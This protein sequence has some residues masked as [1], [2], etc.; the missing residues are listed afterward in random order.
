M[1]S[2]R[3]GL[4]A[5]PTF[6]LLFHVNYVLMGKTNG[7]QRKRDA[8][9]IGTSVKRCRKTWIYTL[10]L[11]TRRP[12]HHASLMGNYNC[13]YRF[14]RRKVSSFSSLA[15]SFYSVVFLFPLDNNIVT[16]KVKVYFIRKW[17][18]AELLCSNVRT[19]HITLGSVVWHTAV[20]TPCK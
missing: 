1:H 9:C 6:L 16:F 4:S 10:L 15:F 18:R 8:N 11:W 17:L 12:H 3:A 13:Q 19:E 2:P 5:L 14:S 7:N 20:V